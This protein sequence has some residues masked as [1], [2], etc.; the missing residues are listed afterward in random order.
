MKSEKK[1][2]TAAKN[3]EG[4]H[5]PPA[6]SARK[7]IT[8]QQNAKKSTG[9]KDT[10][11]TRFN[12]LK[13]GLLA[14]RL[15]FSPNGQVADPGLQRL[16]ESLRK[17]Y[18][19][20]VYTDLLVEGVVT[21]YWRIAQGLK[22]E[23]PIVS[24]GASFIPQGGMGN[25]Q[26]YNTASR[27]ALLK[28]LELLNELPPPSSSNEEDEDETEASDGEPSPT[29]GPTMPSVAQGGNSPD[30]SKPTHGLELVAAKNSVPGPEAG[31]QEEAAVPAGLPKTEPD[32]AV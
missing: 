30:G 24:K 29:T 28:N 27:R 21:E 15:I 6:V 25:L 12:A 16:F 11:H 9:P 1:P 2:N 4:N 32:Q 8:N 31:R 5:N 18:G 7:L 3:I 14:K 10:R 13:H 17:K 19:S 26:R 23:I 20:D 22:V